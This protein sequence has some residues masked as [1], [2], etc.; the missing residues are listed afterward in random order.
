MNGSDERAPVFAW[1]TGHVR[2]VGDSAL[3]RAYVCALR[4]SGPVRVWSGAPGSGYESG[5]ELQDGEA[6]RSFASWLRELAVAIVRSRPSIA[7]N[8]GAFGVTKAYLGGLILLLPLLVALRARGGRIIW[9]GAAVS[10]RRGALSRPFDALARAADLLVWRDTVTPVLMRRG[11]TAPDW[12][13]GLSAGGLW[14]R[15]PARPTPVDERPYIA[16]ALRG[17]RPAPG[18]D[19]LDA[20]EDLSRRLGRQVVCVAQVADDD[21]LAATL[22]VRLGGQH[23]RW[24]SEDHKR[25]EQAVRA[26]YSDSALVLSDRLHALIIAATE[27]AVPLGWT[28]RRTTKTAVHMDLVGAPWAS[29]GEGADAVS[30]IG[31]LDERALRAYGAQTG[32]IVRRAHAEVHA[33][34]A[35]MAALR[36]NG[37]HA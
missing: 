32:S 12:A 27:G 1:L 19:W 18:E 21:E 20:V 8:A 37:A 5:L 10:R 6:S 31:G 3:R 9:V 15:D 11:E 4:E 30:L 28:D 7:F 13:F 35:R 14:T 22:A 36:G 26:W 24:G 2:N 25:Q 33:L 23:A 29:V 34:S 17:D 16:V